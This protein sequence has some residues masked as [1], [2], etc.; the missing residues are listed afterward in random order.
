MNKLSIWGIVIAAAFVVGVLSANPVVEAVGGWQSAFDGLDIRITDLENQSIPESQVYEVSANGILLEGEV[1]TFVEL[2]C[3]DGDW[4][5]SIGQGVGLTIEV[6]DTLIFPPDT[7]V[8]ASGGAIFENP[9]SKVTPRKAIGLRVDV[10][11]F[12]N[13]P[14]TPEAP[15]DI[16][17]TVTTLCLSPSP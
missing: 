9:P 7:V 11:F 17:F 16:P 4:L 3:L 5:N 14:G 2:L 1:F 13:A 15:F 8:D 6:D 12:L 10:E